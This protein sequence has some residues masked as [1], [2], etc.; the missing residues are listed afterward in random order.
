MLLLSVNRFHPFDFFCQCVRDLRHKPRILNL[1]TGLRSRPDC[2]KSGEIQNSGWA[3]IPGLLIYT[4]IDWTVPI[5]DMEIP[6]GL[7][8]FQ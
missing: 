6:V 2:F 5:P 1:D 7:L 4:Y 3:R 8:Y